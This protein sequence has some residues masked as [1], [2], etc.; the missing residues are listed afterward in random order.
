MASTLRDAFIDEVR[1]LYHAEKQ[2]VKALPKLVKGATNSDLKVAL[3][4]HLGETQQQVSRLEDVFGLLGEP[5]RAKTCAGMAGIIEEGADAL[6]E[7][8]EGAVMDAAI[9]ASAQ[10]AE[11]YEIAAYGTAAAWADSLGLSD[12]SALLNETL[13]EEKAADQ[14]LS[15][16]AE[17]GI[18]EAATAGEDGEDEDEGED[19]DDEEAD[20]EDAEPAVP[21]KGMKMTMKTKTPSKANGKP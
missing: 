18:N 7:D 10:R 17:Q 4:N 12:V 21:G 1:D 13:A 6:G 11:H 9:I 5:V 8:F 2:L 3:E 20:D 15:A 14:K 16:L 19:E